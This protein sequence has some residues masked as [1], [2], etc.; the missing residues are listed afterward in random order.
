MQSVIVLCF[1]LVNLL[2]VS[3]TPRSGIYIDNG[4]D[5]TTM[6]RF[7]STDEKKEM[8][9]E[10]LNVLGLPNRPRKVDRKPLNKST[11]NFLLDIY[12]SLTEEDNDEKSR[13]KRSSDVYISGEEQNQIDESDVIMT[14]ESSSEYACFLIGG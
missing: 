4:Y 1:F 10:I 6:E 13:R 3:S 11:L 8:E 12:A 14:F 2:T 9:V 5:Q 7:M